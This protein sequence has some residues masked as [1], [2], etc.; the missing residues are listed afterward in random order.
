ME[1]YISHLLSLIWYA[2]KSLMD[3]GMKRDDI[4][5]FGGN[6]LYSLLEKKVLTSDLIGGTDIYIV[7]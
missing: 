5:F 3:I 7:Y 1:F 4:E 6:K 2:A